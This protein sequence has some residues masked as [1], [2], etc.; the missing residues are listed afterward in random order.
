MGRILRTIAGIILL[1][2]LGG[3]ALAEPRLALVIAN[4][5]Y[6]GG[7]DPL[8][9]PVND[10]KLIAATLQKL[11]FAVTL[12]TDADQKAMKRAIAD[13]GG[14]LEG[15]GPSASA[16]FYYAGHG[17]QVDGQ[18]YLVPVS[19]DIRREADVDL[20]AVSAE[21]VLKQMEYAAPNT[22]IVI[23]DACRNNPLSRG[24]RSGTRGLARM[25]APN[26]SYV[27]Y[28]TAPGQTAA[29]GNGRNSPFALAL[30]DEMAKPGEGIEDVFRNVRITVSKATNGEQTP[31]DSSS[32]MNSFFFAGEKQI[33]AVVPAPAP[34]PVPAPVVAPAA[35]P[36]PATPSIDAAEQALWNGI[37]DSNRVGD[38]AAYLKKYPN[39]VFAELAQSRK[40]ELEVQLASR[41]LTPAPPATAPSAAPA[42]APAAPAPSFQSPLADGTIVLSPEVAAALDNY[43]AIDY[44]VQDYGTGQVAYF[45]VSHDG[46]AYGK[47]V[48]TSSVAQRCAAD[49]GAAPGTSPKMRARKLAVERCKARAKT[50]CVLLFVG[51]SEQA[52]FKLL[53]DMGAPVAAAPTTTAITAEPAAVT[54]APEADFQS[55]LADGTIVLSSSVAAALTRYQADTKTISQKA[56][57]Y[58]FVSPNGK[59]YGAAKCQGSGG[60]NAGAGWPPCPMVEDTQKKVLLKRDAKSRCEATGEGECTMLFY[61]KQQNAPF[62]PVDGANA[63]Q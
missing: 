55:P 13:F 51:R 43:L 23:L 11:G 52:A 16:L 15:A 25:D 42:T 44:P 21:A 4:S 33:A 19:A 26:G 56:W 57:A 22:S 24:L 6:N 39:G 30:A 31:W 12:V 1:C 53:G 32:L 62:K 54:A 58:F 20:E 29:D 5:A 60:G 63:V 41:N 40:E 18:N 46:L 37:K 10:G 45:A 35:A 14:A 27:A 7:M 47:A 49:V 50:E 17:L 28:S 3:P 34:E 8:A 9:N 59:G 36:E 48:C 61:N 2:S 38:Y